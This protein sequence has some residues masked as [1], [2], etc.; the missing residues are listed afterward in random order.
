MVNR[1]EYFVFDWQERLELVGKAQPFVDLLTRVPHIASTGAAVMLDGESGTGKELFARAIHSLSGRQGQLVPINCGAIPDEL[2]EREMFGHKRSAFTGAVTSEAGMVESAEGGTLFLDEVDCLPLPAQAKLLRFVQEKEYRPVGSPTT[3][4]ADVRIIAASNAQLL[5]KVAAGLF[6]LD[7]YYRLNVLPLTLPALRERREDIPLLARYLLAR[8]F[9]QHKRLSN[10]LL[11]LLSERTW[12][13]NVRELQHT[14]ERAAVMSMNRDT[15]DVCDLHI[16]AA[17][18]PGT[19]PF[20]EAKRRVVDEFE[21]TYLRD[22]LN[23]HGGNIANAARAAEKNRRAF[24]ELLRKHSI[25]HRSAR[26][27]DENAAPAMKRD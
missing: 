26:H 2:F 6:R 19:E 27:S 5:D 8:G 23:A 16:S 9:G 20:R 3:R 18:K 1:E 13:G 25:H 22:I 12:P 4:R 17:A 11:G 15:L 21:R 24:W 14:I 7:L 10:R